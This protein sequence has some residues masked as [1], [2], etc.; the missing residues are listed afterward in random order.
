MHL[1]SPKKDF[2]LFLP[3]K[4]KNDIN[5]FHCLSFATPQV[6]FTY[7]LSIANTMI[8]RSF[9]SNQR[10]NSIKAWGG[11]L[12]LCIAPPSTYRKGLRE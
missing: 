7:K 2:L 8:T 4:R 11:G 6:T 9:L 10:I 12:N 3:Y 1:I 5:F